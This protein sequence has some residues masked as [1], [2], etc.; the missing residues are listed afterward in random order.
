MWKTRLNFLCE[1][2]AGYGFLVGH[3]L[4]SGRMTWLASWSFYFDPEQI[5]EL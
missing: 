5:L 1:S 3:G 4:P 2:D